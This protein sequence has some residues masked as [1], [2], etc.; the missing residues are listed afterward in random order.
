VSSHWSTQP[1]TLHVWVTGS[2]SSV[3]PLAE[4]L[5]ALADVASLAVPDEPVPAAFVAVVLPV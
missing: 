5:S 3:D 4:A 1:G 2:T